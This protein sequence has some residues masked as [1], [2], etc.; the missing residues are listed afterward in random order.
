M[1][2]FRRLKNRP[3]AL[4]RWHEFQIAREFA[5][6][7]RRNDGPVFRIGFV[8]LLDLAEIVAVIH[9]QAVRLRDPALRNVTE[10]VD[11]LKP[12]AIA[13]VESRHRIE[14]RAAPAARM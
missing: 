10:Q 8:V 7:R 11:P 4:F 6:R 5:D 1:K 2:Q 13:E 12:R 9:H 14:R 3:A